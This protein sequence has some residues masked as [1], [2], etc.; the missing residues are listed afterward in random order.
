MF[1]HAASDLKFYMGVLWPKP[2]LV[3][4]VRIGLLQFQ[5]LRDTLICAHKLKSRVFRLGDKEGHISLGQNLLDPSFISGY[6]WAASVLR[7][8]GQSW[9]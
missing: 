6:L 4:N 7:Q 1:L 3:V 9:N 8:G 5:F 2:T